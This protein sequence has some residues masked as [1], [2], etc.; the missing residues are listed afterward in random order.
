V[1]VHTGGLPALF[2]ARLPERLRAG[3]AEVSPATG[4]HAL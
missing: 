1:F 4:D 2:A 3:A